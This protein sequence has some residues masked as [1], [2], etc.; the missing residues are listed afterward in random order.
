MPIVQ[1]K[2]RLVIFGVDSW[3]GRETLVESVFRHNFSSPYLLCT[4]HIMTK[5]SLSAHL[6]NLGLLYL[7]CPY[8]SLALLITSTLLKPPELERG[9]HM[10]DRAPS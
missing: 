6:C 10:K 7:Y 8:N 1:W 3:R 4:P 5:L 9:G 2:L